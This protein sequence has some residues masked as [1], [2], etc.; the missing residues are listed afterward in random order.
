MTLIIH[1]TIN[2]GNIHKTGNTCN[3]QRVNN[4]KPSKKHLYFHK[5]FFDKLRELSVADQLGLP[6]FGK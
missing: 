4:Q 2:S 1:Y 5:C 6:L 3:F